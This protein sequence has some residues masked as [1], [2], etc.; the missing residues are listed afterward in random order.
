MQVANPRGLAE[1]WL[2]SVAGEAPLVFQNAFLE[3]MYPGC[4]VREIEA[5]LPLEGFDTLYDVHIHMAAGD[6]V[7]SLIG[8]GNTYDAA[9]MSAVLGGVEVS[10]LG[11][12]PGN[13]GPF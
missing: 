4:I 10:D 6:K 5:R 11:I 8:H 1:Q 3:D 12:D 13:S 7:F 2:E 9:L